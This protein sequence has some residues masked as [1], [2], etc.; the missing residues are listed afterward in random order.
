MGWGGFSDCGALPVWLQEGVWASVS[1]WLEVSP[2][3]LLSSV[4]SLL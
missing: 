2:S 1:D 4:F 3:T